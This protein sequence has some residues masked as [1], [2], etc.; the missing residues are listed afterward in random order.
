MHFLSMPASRRPTWNEIRI[1]Q[2]SKRNQEV[3]SFPPS[4]RVSESHQ[5]VGVQVIVLRSREGKTRRV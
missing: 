5:P 1:L 2:S 3:L 4:S